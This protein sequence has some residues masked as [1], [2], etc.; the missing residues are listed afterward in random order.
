VDTFIADLRQGDRSVYNDGLVQVA[1]DATGEVQVVLA[2]SAGGLSG[3]VVHPDG[4]KGGDTMVVLAPDNALRA[5]LLLYHAAPASESGEF[6]IHNIAPGRYKLFAWEGVPAN[7]WL[8]SQFLAQY[9]PVGIEVTVVP[10]KAGGTRVPVVW[11]K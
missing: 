6:A 9:E 5:N 3:T 10:G 8:N 1:G 11:L 7:A 2:Q 4:K